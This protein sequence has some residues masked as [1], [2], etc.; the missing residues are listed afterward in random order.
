[1]TEDELKAEAAKFKREQAAEKKRRLRSGTINVYVP[2]TPEIVQWLFDEGLLPNASAKIR[3]PLGRRLRSTCAVD[4]LAFA[5]TRHGG[6]SGHPIPL[7]HIG[8]M[9]VRRWR[10]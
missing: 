2:V 8:M 10:R 9:A 7:R 4:P 1:M 6:T 3:R 5:A